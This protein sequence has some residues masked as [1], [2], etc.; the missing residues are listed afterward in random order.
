MAAEKHGFWPGAWKRL[1]DYAKTEFRV[2]LAT[3]DAFPNLNHTKTYVITGIV[4]QI[5]KHYKQNHII[6]EARMF[7]LYEQE[8]Y[9]LI[10]NN[11]S[12]FHC[13]I[14]KICFCDVI[15]HY[16]LKLPS[17]LCEGDTL[18]W[19]RTHAAELI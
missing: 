8:L 2:H 13:E 14:K 1:I 4:R 18:R 12:T 7:S 9:T 16:K 11:T 3:Q 15:T 17:N 6:L 5:L 19:V 10:Y